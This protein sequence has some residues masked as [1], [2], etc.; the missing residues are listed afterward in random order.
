[1]SNHLNKSFFLIFILSALLFSGC[2]VSVP[3]DCTYKGQIAPNEAVSHG[4]VVTETTVLNKEGEPIKTY[5]ENVE[6]ALKDALEKHNIPTKQ[7]PGL[8]TYSLR[9]EIQV[10]PDADLWKY[11]PCLAKNLGMA[12]IPVANCFTPRYYTVSTGFDVDFQLYQGENLIIHDHHTMKDERQV[13]VSQLH[14]DKESMAAA[15]KLWEENR[16]KAIEG[17]FENL[18]AKFPPR[19]ASANGIFP[20]TTQGTP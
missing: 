16:D 6:S 11:E 9:T 2:T 13:K 14:R 8:Q 10:L 3:M 20:V 19:S 7:R 15:V 5:Q 17:F 4:Y 12:I 1:M 18:Q